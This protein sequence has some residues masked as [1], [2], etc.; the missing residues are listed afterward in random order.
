MWSIVVHGGAGAINRSVEAAH[1]GGCT[2]AVEAGAAI[3]ASGGTSVDAVCAAARVLEDDPTF[4]AGRGGALDDRGLVALDAAVMR[5][6]DLA[7]GAVG[8]VVGV[9]RAV[10]LARCVMEDGH[11]VLLAGPGALAFARKKGI[12]IV[13]P[14]TLV[15]KHARN[16]WR[17]RKDEAASGRA[18]AIADWT[19][20]AEGDSD[21]DGET[22]LVG[23]IGAVAKDRAGVIAAATSTGGLTLRYPGRVGDTP[24]A[25]AGTYADDRLGGVSCTGHGE[26]MMRTVLGY[27]VLRD[28][29]GVPASRATEVLVRA[30]DDATARVGGK[31]GMIV[32]LPDGTPVHAHN[33]AHMGCA[34]LRA[35]GVV[36]TDF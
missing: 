6:S 17:R 14:M 36:E 3:L 15:T 21:D 35:S 29:S 34:W 5:G 27:A 22:P 13:D 26:T 2:R 31:G 25:G 32:L 8:A 4:N 33:T 18:S 20:V 19:P 10:D 7:C 9:L 23:T 24:I 1:R 30:L 28:L 12:P 16:E 11:H